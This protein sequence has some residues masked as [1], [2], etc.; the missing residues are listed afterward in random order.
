MTIFYTSSML[1]WKLSECS[2]N[3]LFETLHLLSIWTLKQMCLV[4]SN[5]SF[6]LKLPSLD[7]VLFMVPF[8]ALALFFYSLSLSVSLSLSLSLSKLHF[9]SPSVITVTLVDISLR[10]FSDS[11]LPFLTVCYSESFELFHESIKFNAL[12]NKLIT[13]LFNFVLKLVFPIF[14][15]TPLISWLFQLKISPVL[16]SS[17]AQSCPTLCDHM[18]CSPPG[19]SVH[20]QLPEFTQTHVHWVGDVI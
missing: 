12:R 11:W 16:F 10:T 9:V 17:V 3:F 15:F 7:W 5:Y 6:L 4:L 13:V 14:L 20:H 2:H 18:D 1:C 8:L 19:L